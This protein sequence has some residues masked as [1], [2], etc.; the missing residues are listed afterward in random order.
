MTVG[1]TIDRAAGNDNASAGALLEGAHEAESAARD[2]AESAL[3]VRDELL[4]IRL[5]ARSR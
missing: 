2:A 1:A 5:P 3:G 4:S